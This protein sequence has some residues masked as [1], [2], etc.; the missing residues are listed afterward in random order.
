MAHVLLHPDWGAEENEERKAVD[1]NE[2]TIERINVFNPDTDI[3][4]L[5]RLR[6]LAASTAIRGRF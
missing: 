4:L 3:V 6:T 1:E 5:N 2:K